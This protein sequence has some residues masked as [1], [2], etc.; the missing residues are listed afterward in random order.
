M[1]GD[2]IEIE[3]H[4]TLPER[5]E[6]AGSDRK[7]WPWIAGIAV[8]VAV[9]VAAMFALPSN[10]DSDEAAPSSS[11]STATVERTDVI[12]TEE[13][14]GTLG[15][16]ATD[17]VTYR[18]SP[19]GVT[20][21]TGLASGIVTWIA[22]EGTVIVPG[23]VL[24][25]VNTVPVVVLEGDTPQ[26]RS[27]HSRMSDG[28]DVE[29]LE[30][31][32]VDLGFDPDG[33]IEIDEDFTSATRDAIEL[34]QQSIGADDDGRL[35]LGE[36]LFGP[37]ATYVSVV[38]V[39]LGDQVGPGSA[40]VTTSRALSGTVTYLVDEGETLDQG[41]VVLMV[42]GEPIVMLL[43]E[44]P[45]YRIMELGT[46]G[47]DVRQ[48]QSGL[49]DLGFGSDPDFLVD[50]MFSDATALAVVLWQDSIGARP[51]GIVNLGDIIF[52]KN[53]IRV[54]ASTIAVGDELHDGV[55]IL[56][57]SSN[58]TNVAVQLSTDDQDLVAVGDEVVVILP[59]ESREPGIVSE[60]GTVVQANQ[61][62]A[63]FFDMTVTLVD[64]E[65]APDLDEAPVDVEI[66]SDRADDVL[67]VPVTALLALSEGGY[68][69]EVVVEDGSI[70]LVAV[71]PGLFADGLV[72]VDSDVLAEGMEVVVP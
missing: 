40:I 64:P 51:D 55:P 25:E 16:G 3:I 20:T 36:V 37:V 41:D 14:G 62:G 19:S 63:T 24:Y 58:A 2:D 53:S 28:A 5:S 26:Y 68:A 23:D 1:P 60:I 21:V 61:Q 15:F 70:V 45:A 71:D 22:D 66:V 46:V 6:T 29:Q 69:V 9:A 72:E 42:D 11:L 54:G 67:A 33:D 32:L 30:Q 50:G 38:L 18:T 17:T 13:L 27:F 7:R 35:D 10:S 56:S 4:E 49:R 12:A 31:A 48:L 59:D 47:D 57:V 34:L 39:D 43:G 8:G 44:I 65:A 52:L